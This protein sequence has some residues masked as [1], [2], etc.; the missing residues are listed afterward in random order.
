MFL[1]IGE[2]E[3]V[4]DGIISSNRKHEDFSCVYFICGLITWISVITKKNTSI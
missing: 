3:I 1:Q 4:A 2:P